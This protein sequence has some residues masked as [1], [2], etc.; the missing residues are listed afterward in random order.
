MLNPAVPSALLRLG[1]S[2]SSFAEAETITNSV[3]MKLAAVPAGEFMM[4]SADADEDAR[5]DE[6]PQHLVRITKP[7]WVGQYEVT[8][9][10]YEQVTGANPSW[11]SPTGG[12]QAKAAGLDTSRFPVESVSWLDAVEFCNKLSELPQEKAAGRRY[13]LPT[14]AEWQY[15]CR[16]GTATK[17]HYGDSL[18]STQANINGR[19]PYGGAPRGPYLGRT[20]TV[21]S[22]LP[23]A[24]GLY[25]MHG[26]VTEACADWFGREY[27]RE[28]PTDDPQGPAEGADRMVM[29]G[30]WAADAFQCR[31]AHRRSNATSGV[32][33]YFGFRVVCDQ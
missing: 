8:Q 17:F 6:R 20:T 19:Y 9:A 4:G 13:R 14:E 2:A 1:E 16:A 29:G 23:N 25:D 7:L 30:S 26:N 32:A 31:A 27:Y 3:G 11:F 33:Q 21:G 10:E 18:T 5:E 12:G 24:F 22:Y 15:C 28:S